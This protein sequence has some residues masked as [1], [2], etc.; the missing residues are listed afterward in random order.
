M[1]TNFVILVSKTDACAS[2][3]KNRCSRTITQKQMLTHPHISLNGNG[4]THHRGLF[5]T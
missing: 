4:N 2:S 1:D 3:H 5:A